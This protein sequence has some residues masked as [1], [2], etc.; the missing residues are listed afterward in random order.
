[1]ATNLYSW[2]ENQ[3]FSTRNVIIN[4]LAW[5]ESEGYF[6]MG[7]SAFNNFSMS[8]HWVWVDYNHL[9]SSKCEWNNYFIKNAPKI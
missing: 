9:I 6:D 4:D 2:E 7:S 1:M 5:L 3:A 8:V